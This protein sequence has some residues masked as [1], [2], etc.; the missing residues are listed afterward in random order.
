MKIYCLICKK[1]FS[2]WP[3][4]NRKYCSR[5]CFHKKGWKNLC[6]VCNKSLYKTKKIKFCSH[7]CQSISW[8]KENTKKGLC[9]ICNKKRVSA[10]YCMKHQIYQKLRMHNKLNLKNYYNGK[11]TGRKIK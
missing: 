10:H 9:Q 2:D 6:V 8:Q 1:Q 7:V 11:I 4:S 5:N 3:S